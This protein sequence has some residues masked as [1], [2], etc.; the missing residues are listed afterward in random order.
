ME[1]QNCLSSAV[2]ADRRP[3]L[4]QALTKKQILDTA[5]RVD[6]DSTTDVSTSVLIV[7]AT[8]NDMEA[9]NHIVVSTVKKIVQLPESICKE[10][11]F[12]RS[13]ND[14]DIPSYS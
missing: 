12:R 3:R 5:G 14:I 4:C 2:A 1:D 8:V 7:E 9:L 10:G 13:L 6:V 11:M